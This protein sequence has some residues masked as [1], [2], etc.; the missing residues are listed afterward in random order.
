MKVLIHDERPDALE[1]L[2]GSIINYGY[3]AGIAKDSPEIIS[4]LSDERYDVVL[5]NGSYG[6]LKQDQ[7]SRMKSASVFVIGIKD[8][9]RS[10]EAMDPT[11]DMYL[12]R[13]FGASE[14]RQALISRGKAL[15]NLD[16]LEKK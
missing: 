13:P 16:K 14:L 5:T 7:C 15:P 3:G 8:P 9:M 10:N 6:D 1:F 2:L 12:Y 11:V 4:M